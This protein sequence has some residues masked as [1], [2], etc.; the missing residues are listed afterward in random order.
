MDF[1]GRKFGRLT[2]LKIVGMAEN[3]QKIY[4]CKCDCGTVKKIRRGALRSGA[5]VSCGCYNREKI[6]GNKNNYK[7][8]LTPWGYHSAPRVYKSWSG[9]KQRCYNPK[10]KSY[11]NY[12]G[13]GITMCE[14]WKNSFQA[15]YDWSIAHGYKDTLSIDRINNNGNYCPENC[16][17]ATAKQQAN[18]RRPRR[19]K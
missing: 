4:L 19:K 12:G 7:H 8:G 16:R 9:M 10:N 13:R 6:L 17:W 3:Y 15:F 1:V 14:E 18:N 2:V 5:T 11:I